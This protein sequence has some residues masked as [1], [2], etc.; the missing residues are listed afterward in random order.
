MIITRT[1]FRA[2]FAGGGSD[3]PSFYEKHGGCVLSTSINKYMYISVHP[4]FELQDTVLKYSETETVRDISDIQHKYFKSVLDKLRISGVEITSTADIPAGTGLG[5]SSSF[6]VGVLHALYSYKGKF[7]SKEKLASTACDV[8]INTLKN[9]IGKQDQY[10]AAYGGLNFYSFNRDGSVFVEP[11]IM[12]PEAFYKLEKNLMM[13]YTGKVHSASEIL[14]EQGRNITAGEKEAN[15]LQ[16]CE[17]AREL[18]TE[19]QHNN[20][21]AMGEILHEGWKLKR[22]LATGITSNTI[23]ELYEIAMKKGAIGGKLLGAGGGGFLL[24]Y[25]P[26]ERQQEVRIA[27]N[28]TQMPISLDRQGSS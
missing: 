24:F 4:S 16:M 9:P 8:E 17:L 26:E 20:I 1:P 12:R 25:V 2:S 23:D 21:D 13:F 28:L 19:L 15:Q 11:I 22:T 14:A 5:S 27:L 10:A 7:V 6:T 3:I 18:R